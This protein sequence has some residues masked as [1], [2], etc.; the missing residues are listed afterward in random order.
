MKKLKK[1]EA[2]LQKPPQAS[3]AALHCVGNSRAGRLYIEWGIAEKGGW[4]YNEWE[5]QN[6]AA[7]H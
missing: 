2:A 1:I 3:W 5:Q 7:L 4:L 6:R